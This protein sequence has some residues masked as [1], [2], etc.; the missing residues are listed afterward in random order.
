VSHC[1]WNLSL[2]SQR[3]AQKHTQLPIQPL[4]MPTVPLLH[5]QQFC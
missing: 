1:C 3:G 2:H 4:Q 5:A